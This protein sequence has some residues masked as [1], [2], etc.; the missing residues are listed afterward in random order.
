MLGL[1]L[2]LSPLV[3]MARMATGTEAFQPLAF[4]L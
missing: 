1:S 3:S 4:S 2:L